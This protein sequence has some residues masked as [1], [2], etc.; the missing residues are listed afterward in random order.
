MKS[1]VNLL[2]PSGYY[3]EKIWQYKCLHCNFVRKKQAV[4]QPNRMQTHSHL[5]GLCVA[6][7]HDV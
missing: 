7:L 4:K 3:D 2:F 5:N 6:R 1:E